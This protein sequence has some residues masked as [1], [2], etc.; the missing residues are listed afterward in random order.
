M[1][2]FDISHPEHPSRYQGEHGWGY[3]HPRDG[4]E[5]RSGTNWNQCGK[6]ERLLNGYERA[7]AALQ[8]L[9]ELKKLKEKLDYHYGFDRV[10]ENEFYEIKNEYERRKPIV[11]ETAR[12]LV[13]QWKGEA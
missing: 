1:A 13:A 3:L 2:E 7:M 9:D 4:W 8:E 11:W 10:S 5:W 12:A 6:F